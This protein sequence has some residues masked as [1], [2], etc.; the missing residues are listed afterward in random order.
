MSSQL[1][2]LTA[3]N[4]L[5]QWANKNRVVLT[6]IV[7]IFAL[8]LVTVVVSYAFTRRYGMYIIALPVAV[9][10]VLTLFRW[11]SLG[12]VLF[13]VA[14]MML[15]MSIPAV[16]LAAA[17]LMGL[18]GLWLVDMLILKK[19]I[20]LVRSPTIAPILMFI[21]VIFLSFGVGQ[22]PWFSIAPAPLD[23]QIGSIAI[24]ILSLCAFLLVAHQVRDD[25]WLKAMTF[26]F[27]GLGAVIIL[28]GVVPSLRTLNRT[29]F[30]P[31]IGG[32]SMFWIWIVT[33]AAAQAM[34]NKHLPKP[35]RALVGGVALATLYVGI[36]PGRAWSSGW[37]P[38]LIGLIALVW[39]GAPRIALPLTMVGV[40]LAVFGTQQIYELVYVGDNEYSALTRVEAWRIVLEI[41]KVNPLLGLGPANYYFYTPLFSILGFYVKFNSHNNYVDIIAQTGLLGLICYFWFVVALARTGWYLLPKLPKD[42]FEF[43][44]VVGCMGG[45]AGTV[46]AGM[47]G[48]WV[49]PFVYNVGIEGLRASGIGWLF[50]GGIVAMEQITAVRARLAKPAP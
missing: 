35:V 29:F 30:H 28:A 8:L 26:V 25:K 48:D 23:N 6:R 17:L 18:T 15:K 33:L 44:Y 19:S 46:V 12:F 22:F 49:L 9:A 39:V 41:A 2:R 3:V 13:I 50:L 45:L 24:Y 40:G 31:K 1:G 47:L 10:G 34:F 42:S 5:I 36:G 32:G 27:I 7:V 37:V 16:G 20:R 43:A 38:P 21:V 4:P 14:S 11:P